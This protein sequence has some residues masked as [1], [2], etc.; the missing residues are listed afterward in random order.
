MSFLCRIFGHRWKF[1]TGPIMAGCW[2]RCALC[3]IRTDVKSM[4]PPPPAPP[5]PPLRMIKQSSHCASCRRDEFGQDLRVPA[6]MR[7]VQRLLGN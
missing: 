1:D 3:G 2:R 7:M 4:L 6:N 5:S